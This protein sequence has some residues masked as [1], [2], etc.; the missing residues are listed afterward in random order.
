MRFK[1]K[2]YRA[3]TSS[4]TLSLAAVDEKDSR[5]QALELGFQVISVSRQL[6]GFSFKVGPSF[7]IA[8]FSEE[9][10]ALLEAGLSLVETVDA[11]EQ[12]SKTQESHQ[13]LGSLL[14][15]LREGKTFSQALASMPEVFPVLYVA[16][17]RTSERTGDLVEALRRYLAYHRQLNRVR[18]KVVAASVYPLLLMAVGLL[19]VL[20]LLG[21]V[22]PRFS[23][24]YED[25]GRNLPWMSRVLMKW[26]QFISAYG[27]QTGV[28]TLGF[29]AGTTY[30]LFRSSVKARLLKTL[31]SLPVIGKK[32]R[33]YQ[34]ARFTRTLAMLVNGG[35]PFVGALEMVRGLLQQPA[36]QRGLTHAAIMVREGR[37]VSDAFASN[38]LA[39]DVG[40]RLLIVGERS[41]E[42]GQSL[43]RIAGLY[44]DEIARWVDWFTKLFEPL[45]MIGIGLVIGT[46]V[47]LMYL[48]IFELANSLQ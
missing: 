43:E 17:I 20:F 16:T 47:V 3:S 23:L 40:V 15:M 5:R 31:W 26:G 37:A 45:L 8:L 25:L 28:A 39:T 29:I 12:K 44:D 11:L 19:V 48:P 18:E 33:L 42:L 6:D 24:V 34:L 14:T 36:L 30:L 41:G 32:I 1:L 27:W 10:L 22:V 9:L 38:G 4:R 7:S 46:I 13:I 35:I 21:Y 2:V